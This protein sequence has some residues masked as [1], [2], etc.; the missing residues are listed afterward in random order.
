MRQP[1]ISSPTPKP[2]SPQGVCV[3][4]F[5]R[6]GGMGGRAGEREA[7]TSLYTGPFPNSGETHRHLH[8]AVVLLE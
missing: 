6:M 8:T 4:S 2:P 7:R 5:P 3:P 1:Q